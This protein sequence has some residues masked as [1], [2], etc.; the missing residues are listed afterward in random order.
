MS[1]QLVVK[2]LLSAAV[3]TMVSEIARRNDRLGALLV[4]LPFVSIITVVW[5]HLENAP[6]LRQQKTA[7]H[8]YYTFYY[9]LPTLP[10]FLLFPWMQRHLGFYG[11]LGA[12]ALLTF[13]LFCL[14][15]TVAGR[16]GL[17]L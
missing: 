7:D 6:E 15:K 1:A 5:I 14:L 2:Y 12:G 3:I 10:M 16:F 17:V 9:V 8:M 13:A 4:S 11:A